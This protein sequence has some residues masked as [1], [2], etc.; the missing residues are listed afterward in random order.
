MIDAID[1]DIPFSIVM[2]IMNLENTLILEF[3][4][5]KNKLKD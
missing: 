5:N 4:K 1:P 2:K 3:I